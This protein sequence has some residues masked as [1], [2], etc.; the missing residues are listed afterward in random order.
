MTNK[1]IDF[2]GVPIDAFTME[3]TINCIVEH[4]ERQTPAQHMAINPAKIMH[5]LNM[6]PCMGALPC[7]D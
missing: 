4:I 1:R 7:A 5:M 3:E 2:L 6:V